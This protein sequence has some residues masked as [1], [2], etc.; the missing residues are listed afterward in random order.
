M[1]RYW[2]ATLL[3]PGTAGWWPRFG[4]GLQESVCSLNCWRGLLDLSPLYVGLTALGALVLARRSGWAV[5]AVLLF[6]LGAAFAGSLAGRYPL[7]TRL[8]LFSAPQVIMLVAVGLVSACEWLERR[9]VVLR[10]RW[11]LAAFLLPSLILTL[12][13]AIDPPEET[14]FSKE[15]VRPLIERLTRDA[16]SDPVYVYHRATPAWIFYTTDWSAPDT[17]RLGWAARV[18]G[19]D[20]LAFVNGPSLGPRRPEQ[21]AE[22]SRSYAGRTELLGAH[23]G[24]QGRM[25]QSYVPAYPDSGWADAEAERMRAVGAPRVWMVLADF[26]HPPEDDGQALREAVERLGGRV[27]GK[28]HASEAQVLT[29]EFPESHAR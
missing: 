6:P 29:I 20:G 21:A 27:I 1:H 14:G 28:R 17:A 23:S 5:P 2:A 10:A 15:E 24:S 22:L 19:P 3:V 25:W 18:G 7:A 4:L 11:L 26:H 8:L 13:L 16:G 12:D 9:L